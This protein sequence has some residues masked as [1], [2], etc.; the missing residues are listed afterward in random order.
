[1][2]L[3]RRSAVPV[4]LDLKLG[5][6][7]GE[8]L[9]AAAYYIASEA[10]ANAAAAK[11]R[12]L[13]TIHN[14]AQ[15]VPL[16]C[17]RRRARR[18]RRTRPPSIDL[19]RTSPGIC[20]ATAHYVSDVAWGRH[21]AFT[22]VSIPTTRDTSGDP[23]AAGR[24][25]R[26]MPDRAEPDGVLLRFPLRRPPGLPEPH[27]SNRATRAALAAEILTLLAGA[28]EPG[29][30]AEDTESRLTGFAEL[31]A[32]AISDALIR[33]ELDNS[34]ARIVA[35]ADESRRRIERDLHDGAQQRLATLAVQLR[36]AAGNLNAGP[37]ELRDVLAQAAN[38][39]I[40]AL[41][42]VREIARGIHPAVLS[43]G[44]LAPALRALARR[45]AVPVKLAVSTNGRLAKRIEV[46]AYYVVAE[47]LTNAVKHA[48]ASVVRVTVEQL[49]KTLHLSVR[50]DGVGGADP[51][52]GSGLIGLRDRVEAIGGTV[53]IQSPAGVGTTVLVSLPLD[54]SV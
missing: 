26:Q 21:M 51:A 6:R 37:E 12:H 1:M 4:T 15:L 14:P 2:T 54:R 23:G 36:A 38:A 8:H 3:G 13:T 44:G 42:E 17:A 47:L 34:R 48:R 43:E 10:L 39:V 22:S 35:A 5:S 53:I 31:V 49:D 45:S 11:C 19:A 32:T 18:S 20:P 9:E 52:G 28:D 16:T 33:A 41:N 27:P 29:L 50:D 24:A 40:A 46:T 25:L 7:P 30:G